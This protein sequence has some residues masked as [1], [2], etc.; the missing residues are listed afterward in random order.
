MA[1]VT[2]TSPAPPIGGVPV[3][4]SSIPGTVVSTGT[5][6]GT[7]VT[8]V[9]VAKPPSGGASL[10]TYILIGV[11]FL[12]VIIIWLIAIFIMYFAKSG[13]FT[14][15]YVRPTPSNT[16][17]V[18]VNG[19]TVALTP[20]EQATLKTK[21]NE[22]L[23]NLG[24][25]TTTTTTTTTTATTSTTTSNTTGNTIINYNNYSNL[26]RLPNIKTPDYS[27]SLVNNRAVSRR[28]LQ[29]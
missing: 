21:I 28:I 27:N 2:T 19:T 5:V 14:N 1:T 23:N 3:V 18:P 6:T 16:D 11:G 7:P 10:L 4:I 17:L 22:A 20:A 24:Q 26:R 8:P 9:A 12:V 15:S 25:T 13:L 29:Q